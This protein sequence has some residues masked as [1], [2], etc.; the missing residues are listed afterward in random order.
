[1]PQIFVLIYLIF[2]NLLFSQE[3]IFHANGEI[4]SLED[5]QKKFYDSQVLIL[6]EEHNDKDGHEWKLNLIKTFSH[7]VKFSISMEMLERDQQIIIDEYLQGIYDES[8]FREN[9]RLWNNWNDYQPIVEFAKESKLRVLAANPPRRYVR[10]ISRKGIQIWESFPALAYLYLPNLELVQKFRDKNYESK[11]QTALGSSHTT[12]LE[13]LL[14]AQHVW[15][16]SM[17]EIISREVN[18]FKTK[19][20]HI[21]GRFHSDNFLGVTH[22]LRQRNIGVVT[23]SIIP[24]NIFHI[25]RDWKNLADF[26]VVS[27]PR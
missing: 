4:A 2:V 6:G 11:F 16:E 1:M 15:D 18:N 21:N 24:E 22:R 5:I 20:I 26:I 7:N 25:L 19:V 9:M 14:F 12:N 13:N 23:V 3:E 10:A 8:M 17:A 27:K